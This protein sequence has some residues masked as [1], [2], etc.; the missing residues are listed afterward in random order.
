MAFNRNCPGSG[1]FKNP[2]PESIQCISCGNEIEIWSDEMKVRCRKC[3][4]INYKDRNLTCVEWCKFAKECL[5]P[6]LYSKLMEE[7]NGITAKEEAAKK[8][9]AYFLLRNTNDLRTKETE[10]EVAA[11]IMETENIEEEAIKKYS[12]LNPSFFNKLLPQIMNAF[13]TEKQEG[14][15]SESFVRRLM[16]E[17]QKIFKI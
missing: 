16:D 1:S 12:S 13:S 9:G 10:S 15:T 6:E 17:T 8:K 3:G 4:T 2:L 7:K 5:G 14:E 11:D